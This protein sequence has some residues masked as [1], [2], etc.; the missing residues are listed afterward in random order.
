ML[1]YV[2]NLV[3]L[4]LAKL[5]GSSITTSDSQLSRDLIRTRVILEKIRPLEGK[6][7]YQIEKLV[8]KA[9]GP[10]AV[11][12]EGRDEVVN[13][14]LAFKPN[15]SALMSGGRNGG[16][17]SDSDASGSDTEGTAAR[18]VR[19]GAG[20][21][22][23]PPRLAPTPYIEAPTGKNKKARRPPPTASAFLTDMATALNANTP[24]AEGTSGL[25][26]TPS[27]NS[28]RAKKL[29]EMKDYEEGMM[30]RISMNKKQTRQRR[31]DEAEVAL[32]GGGTLDT[33]NRKG[34]RGKGGFGVEFDE[35][36]NTIDKGGKK[37]T[38]VMGRVGGSEYEAM[39]LM[40]NERKLTPAG[41]QSGSGKRK[42]KGKFDQAVDRVAKRA[43][44]SKS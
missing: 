33:G 34:V 3:L 31:D 38:G 40:K 12:E 15:P 11:D 13:D 1:S 8:R 43:K 22:Y 37:R 28:R 30:T 18:G 35:L 44:K 4:S 41:N 29:N 21:V 5:S 27:N 39:R 42:A 7:R 10:A 32:G 24:Y 6:L 23:R 36:L 20:G 19:E 9:D 16:F 17:V 2:H 25:S 26:V 14:P